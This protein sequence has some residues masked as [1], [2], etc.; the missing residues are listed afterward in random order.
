MVDRT[1]P[2]DRTDG[3]LEDLGRHDPPPPLAGNGQQRAFMATTKSM[4]GTHAAAI[5]ASMIDAVSN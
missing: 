3:G 5:A 4:L 1:S 2:W